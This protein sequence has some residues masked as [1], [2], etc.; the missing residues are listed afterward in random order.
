MERQNT[1]AT[2][3]LFHLPGWYWCLEGEKDLF[4]LNPFQ[5]EY[6]MNICLRVKSMNHIL[7]IFI[8]VNQ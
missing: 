2:S 6:L 8:I 5:T 4:S 3:S 7:N 1:T